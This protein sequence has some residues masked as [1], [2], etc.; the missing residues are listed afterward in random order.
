MYMILK[1]METVIQNNLFTGLGLQ[2]VLTLVII[3]FYLIMWE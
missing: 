2:A 3:A 1:N